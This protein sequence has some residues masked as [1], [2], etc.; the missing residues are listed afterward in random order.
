MRIRELGISE[1]MRIS[2]DMASS[3][4]PV[5]VSIPRV[6]LSFPVTISTPDTAYQ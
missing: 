6:N 4:P 2:Q 5:M 1:A 3:K